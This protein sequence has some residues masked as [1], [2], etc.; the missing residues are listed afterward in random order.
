MSEDLK[1]MKAL[2]KDMRWWEEPNGP[3]N[4]VYTD[5][6][7]ATATD[8]GGQVYVTYTPPEAT[9]D[10]REFSEGMRW[11][12]GDGEGDFFEEVDSDVEM[13]RLVL[14]LEE[15]MLAKVKSA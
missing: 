1:W 4:T 2:P 8:D 3:L 6:V 10:E 9:G 14:T 7:E 15:R 5:V 11:A 12:V 13:R